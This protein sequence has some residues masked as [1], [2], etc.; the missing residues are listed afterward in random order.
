MA[1]LI[2]ILSILHS[3]RAN[4][5]GNTTDKN[6]LLRGLLLSSSAVI[7][8]AAAVAS[9]CVILLFLGESV[10]GVGDASHS[11]L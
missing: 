4:A 1:T 6:V 9:M 8:P 2:H 11:L 10:I 5:V 7:V 3:K